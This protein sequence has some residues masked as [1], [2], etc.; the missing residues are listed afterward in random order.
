MAE[1]EPGIE[2]LVERLAE[3]E[4]AG[5]A[6]F[7]DQNLADDFVGIGPRGF[8]L[9]KAE[10]VDR[11]RSGD[12]RYAE[13]KTE[14]VVIRVPGEETAIAT[15]KEISTVLYQGNS[16]P[17][18]EFRIMEVFVRQ[19]HSNEWHL[20]AKQLSPILTS[21]SRPPTAADTSGGGQRGQEGVTSRR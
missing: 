6:G 1:I 16:M 20:A 12:L 10:W 11:H 15:A 21:P 7:L 19:E 8:M 5:D 2:E 13:L 18:G 4:R 14:D 17:A 3:A 9:S